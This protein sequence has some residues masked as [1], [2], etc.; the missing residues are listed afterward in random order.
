MAKGR[1][2][3]D[4]EL[5]AVMRG[6]GY[7]AG[8]K[9]RAEVVADSAEFL[10]EKIESL[11]APRGATRAAQLP[12]A[13]LI[14]CWVEGWTAD[15]AAARLHV[16]PR[17]MSRERSRAI[18]MLRDALTTFPADVPTVHEPTTWAELTAQLERIETAVV[19]IASARH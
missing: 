13:V 6:H 10:R 14:L 12:H 11:R 3:Y 1:V 5:I 8:D 9:T 18:A 2:V 4:P 15:H 19:Q 17:Q 7:V 16:S